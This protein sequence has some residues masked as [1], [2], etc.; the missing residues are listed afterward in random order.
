MSTSINLSQP[1]TLAATNETVY[2][3]CTCPPDKLF[4]E[5]DNSDDLFEATS[6]HWLASLKLKEDISLASDQLRCLREKIYNDLSSPNLLPYSSYGKRETLER[7]MSQLLSLID[8]FMSGLEDIKNGQVEENV[9][10]TLQCLSTTSY[11]YKPEEKFTKMLCYIKMDFNTMDPLIPEIVNT[12]RKIDINLSKRKPFGNL[13]IGIIEQYIRKI[14]PHPER[15]T[16]RRTIEEM[17]QALALQLNIADKNNSLLIDNVLNRSTLFRI[18]SKMDVDPT[19]LLEESLYNLIRNNP[20][21]YMSYSVVS[22][23]A[24]RTASFIAYQADHLLA[25]TP[26]TAKFEAGTAILQIKNDQI[27]IMD[28]EAENKS[29]AFLPLNALNLWHN[30]TV[31]LSEKPDAALRQKSNSISYYKSLWLFIYQSLFTNKKKRIEVKKTL[32]PEEVVGIIVKK[33]IEGT[34][35]FECEVVD[36]GYEGI[37][38]TLDARNDIV[39]YHPG[40]INVDTFRTDGQPM[41]LPAIATLDEEG[42]YVFKMKAMVNDFMNQHRINHYDYRSRVICRLNSATAGMPR[43]PAISI[44]GLSVSVG[45]TDRKD[46]GLLSSGKIVECGNPE[47]GPNCYMNVTYLADRPDKHFSVEQAFHNLMDLYRDEEL[48]M[49]KEERK[50]AQVRETMKESHVYELMYIIEN[51]ASTEENYIKAYN[52]INVCKVLAR[53]LG[54]DQERFYEKR[55]MLIELLSDFDANNKFT[56]ENLRL[57]ENIA[58][59]FVNIGDAL[60][61]RF[62]ELQVVSWIE[63]TEHNDELYQLSNSRDNENLRQLAAL[64]MSYNFIKPAGLMKEASEILNKIRELLNLKRE[65]TDKKFYGKEDYMTEFK[66]SVVYPEKSMYPDIELQTKKILSEICAFL[67]REGGTLYLGVNDQ[68]YERGLKED[69]SFVWFKGNKDH[70]EDYI[71]N[72]VVMQLSKE[73]GHYVQTE[74]DKDPTV[75]TEVLKICV[76]PCPNPISLDGIYYERLCKTCQR[77]SEDYLPTFLENRKKWAAHHKMATTEEAK[78]ELGKNIQAIIEAEKAQPKVMAEDE[79]IATS[80][81]RNNILHNWE[82]GYEEGIAYLCFVGEDSYEILDRDCDIND[83]RLELIIHEEDRDGWLVMMYANGATAKVPVEE[84]LERTPYRKFKRYRGKKLIFAGI[85]KEDDVVVTGFVDARGNKR[86]RLDD[87]SLFEEGKMQDEGIKPS[88]VENYG[89]HYADVA[90][91]GIFPDWVVY[92][93]KRTELGIPINTPKG[94]E[95]MN[96]LLEA[97][98]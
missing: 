81:F 70:Y 41:V 73:A 33:Q 30:M 35:T 9:K 83:C 78:Q 98:K 71:I 40:F 13:W 51:Y 84:L 91:K 17:I 92:N 96:I 7:R 54:T 38:G 55:L 15:L 20:Q 18:A 25:D 89:V 60:Y 4:F 88:D 1:N 97:W 75:K 26:Q 57:L 3:D 94:E 62:R 52:Y 8:D 27:T 87:L 24:I 19:K 82:E 65:E 72:Q 53:M 64:V 59:E 47:Q 49:G 21:A 36:A 74:W 43:V 16:E 79:K 6:Y 10:K 67:N 69:L 86:L 23:D 22:D 61:E 90:P 42:R 31:R 95:M 45:V 50:K 5:K 14:Y 11:V 39:N 46:L 34:L 37:T 29:N 32:M 85:A 66:T 58:A 76:H 48:Y 68:G 12:L 44:D 93:T 63:T 77:V 80:P 56:A 28:Q 2:E